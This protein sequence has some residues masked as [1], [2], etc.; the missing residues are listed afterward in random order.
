MLGKLKLWWGKL[1]KLPGKREI[2]QL[3]KYAERELRMAG[4]YDA[5]SDYG[6]G[7]AHAVM[8]LVK[9]FA[10]QGH[11]GFSAKATLDLFNKVANW[12][13]IQPLMGTDDEWTEHIDGCFQNKRCSRVFKDRKD[14]PAYDIDGRVFRDSNGAYFTDKNSKVYIKFPYT[15]KTE[16]V[17]VLE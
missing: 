4:I 9:A 3:E 10:N 1:L 14:D 17:D 5:D 6:G 7:L 2:T 16:Y 8:G 12:E 15:P 11:S 13:P